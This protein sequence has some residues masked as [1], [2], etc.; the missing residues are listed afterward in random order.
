[1][2]LTLFL[3]VLVGLIWL[4]ALAVATVVALPVLAVFGC[5]FLVWKLLALLG[6]GFSAA[7][8]KDLRMLEL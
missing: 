1:M 4:I 8:R 3:R 5:L 6:G 7:H 2:L